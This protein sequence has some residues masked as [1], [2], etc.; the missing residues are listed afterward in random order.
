MKTKTEIIEN[1]EEMLELPMLHSLKT[2]NLEDI[3]LLYDAIKK[4]CK[5]VSS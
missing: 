2:V 5:K 4:R 1:I 3:K